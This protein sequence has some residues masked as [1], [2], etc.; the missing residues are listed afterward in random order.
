MM[1]RLLGNA[2]E[3]YFFKKGGE[4]MPSKANVQELQELTGLLQGSQAVFFCE[5]KGLTVEQIGQIRAKI[6][7]AQGLMRIAKNTLFSL[8][9]KEVGLPVPEEMLSGP[10]V[11]TIAYGDPVV[12][13]KTLTDYIKTTKSEAL[14]IK[15]AL[16]EKRLLGPEDVSVLAT[17]PSRDVLLAQVLGT[18]EAPIRGLVTV[19]SGNIR[20]LVTCLDQIAK[21]KEK[22]AA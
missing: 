1:I 19:L 14:K 3:P 17:L 10:N 6:R 2:Q 18:M 9:L 8:A 16:L 22:E 12:V 4:G 5:Y 20:G 13:A 15:G 7:E 21:A 11:F